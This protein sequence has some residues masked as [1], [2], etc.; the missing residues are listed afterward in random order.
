MAFAT[1]CRR[2]HVDKMNGAP[3]GPF[4]VRIDLGEN[5]YMRRGHTL[6]MVKMQAIWKK[7]VKYSFTNRLHV[8][9]Y[10]IFF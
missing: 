8:F 9:A 4:R 3:V 5:L 1:T 6:E 10:L 7:M 2:S